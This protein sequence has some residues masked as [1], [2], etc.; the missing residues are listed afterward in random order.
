MSCSAPR[1]HIVD[2]R[3][4]SGGYTTEEARKVFCDLRRLQRW[5]DVEVAL[6]LSQAEL[7]I[8]PESAA[9]ELEKTA[10]LDLLDLDEI[11]KDIARTG[12]S[13]IPLLLR[14]IL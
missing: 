4:Y 11:K 9:L 5:L 6:A 14:R 8:I 10:R 2:S 13:L 3:F 12:H 7:G 1:S